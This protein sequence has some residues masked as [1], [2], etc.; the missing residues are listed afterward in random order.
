MARH[1]STPNGGGGNGRSQTNEAFAD[2]SFLFGGNAAYIEQLYALYEQNPAAVDAEW[3]EFFGG[4]NDD[5][6]SVEANARGASWKRKNWPLAPQSELVAALDGQ[7]P[8]NEKALGRQ[9]QGQGGSQRQGRDFRRRTAARHP[10]LRARHH[11]DPRLSHARPSARRSRS[12]GPRAA[13]G[14]RGAASLV[15]RLHGSRLRPQNL[16][17]PCARPGL[18]DDPRDAGDPAPHLLLDHRLGVHAHFRSGGK[19]LDSGTHRRSGQGGQPSP[20]KASAPSCK[21]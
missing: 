9:D 16:H 11:D 18:R 3:R 14:S 6:A 5:A 7:W 4:L 19:G 12:A 21:S 8:V 13:E 20:R 2:S 1:D 15:L 10:R 17:R